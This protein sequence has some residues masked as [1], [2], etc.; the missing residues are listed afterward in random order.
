MVQIVQSDKCLIY[1]YNMNNNYLLTECEVFAGKSQTEA[2]RIDRVIG[3][4][5]NDD[6][7]AKDD[8]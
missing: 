8:A 4:L 7:G 2:C 6:G 3:T 5:T 1:T